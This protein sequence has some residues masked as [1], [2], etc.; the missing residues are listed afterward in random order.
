MTKRRTKQDFAK[1]IKK[2]IQPYTSALKIHIVLDNLNTHF[3]GSFYETFPKEEAEEILSR[4]EFHYTPKHASWL[5]MAE[6]EINVL[7]NQCIPDRIPTEALLVSRIQ[8]WEAKRNL[9]KKKILWKFTQQDADSKLS[10]H[11]IP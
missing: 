1:F 2:L 6:I 5:D 8:A 3:A 10:H 7:S 11:Y 4:I 9:E